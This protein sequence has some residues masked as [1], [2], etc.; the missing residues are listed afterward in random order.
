MDNPFSPQDWLNRANSN[1]VLATIADIENMPDG[2]YIED[3]CFELQQSAE[4]AIKSVLVYYEVKFPKIHDIST[5][6]VLLKQNTTLEIPDFIKGASILTQ[7]AVKT[8][9]PD[10]RNIPKEEYK[11]ALEIAKSVYN[12]A[13]QQIN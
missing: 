9:Y 11:E 2:L 1:L 7:Y 10:W 6:I 12:W 4:K 8:R 13:K 3:L 5:L